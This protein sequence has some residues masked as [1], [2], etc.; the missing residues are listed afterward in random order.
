MA[1]VYE[2]VEPMLERRVAIKV[3]HP[4]LSA[5]PGFAKRFHQEARL[6]ASLRHPNI[7]Q[8]YDFDIQDGQP[9]MV[10]EFLEGGTLKDKFAGLRSRRQLLPLSEVNRLIASLA[11]AL[12]YAHARGAI[13]RDIKPANILFTSQDEPVISDFGIAKLMHE[14]LQI[15]ATGSIIGTPAY[16][17][18]EQARGVSLDGRSDQYSLGIMAYELVAGRVP[19]QAETP[20]GVIM[21]HLS[22]SP[23]PPRN[24]NS[25]L[26]EPLQAAI[27]QTLAKDPA[28]RFESCGAFSIGFAAAL[29]G[30][31][32]VP[33]STEMAASLN[34]TTVLDTTPDGTTPPTPQPAPLTTSPAPTVP[35]LAADQKTPPSLLD[36]LRNPPIRKLMLRTGIA[37]LL[38]VAII[39]GA[40]W[41]NQ[42]TSTQPRT[43]NGFT[44]AIADFDGS[45][46]SLRVDF[47]RRIYDALQ[48][49]LADVGEEITILQLGEVVADTQ[50]AQAALRDRSAS[51]L[52]WGWYDD[53]GVSP[54]VEVAGEPAPG[55]SASSGAPWVDVALAAEPGSG[56]SIAGLDLKLVAPVI[57][58]PKVMPDMEFFV[59]NGPQQIVYITGAVLGLAFQTQGKP[60]VALELYDRAIANVPL[61]E[62]GKS[63]KNGPGLDLVYAR[64]AELQYDQGN[65]PE[66]VADLEHAVALNPEFYAAQYNLGMLYPQVCRPARQLGPALEAARTAATLQADDP[67]AHTLLASLYYQ[68][69]DYT[70]AESALQTA[71]QL[72]GEYVEALQ[73]L[74]D[75]RRALGDA[76]GAKQ[77]YQQALGLLEANLAGQ[78]KQALPL[79]FSIG[80]L[81][82][83]LDQSEAARAS[84]QAAADAQP[85]AALTHFG[86]G[87]QA[88]SSAQ[89]DLAEREYQAFTQAES[90]NGNAW[91]LLGVAQNLN[92]KPAQAIESL[93]RADSLLSCDSA[94]SLILGG[95]YWEQ[96]LYDQA[97]QAFQ[98]VLE[99]EPDNADAL[100]LLGSTYISQDKLVEAQTALEGAVAADGSLSQARDALGFVY[101]ETGQYTQAIE[102][103]RA[104]V[105]VAPQDAAAW[106][107]LGNAYEKNGELQKAIE[108]YQQ[109]LTIEESASVH[110]YLGLIY[111]NLGQLQEAEE[112][113]LQAIEI[114][115]TDWLAYSGLGEL[116][117]GQGKLEE[118]EKMY[119]QALNLK[120][121]AMLYASLA[122]V[123][124][125]LGKTDLAASQ[126]EKALQ[127]G[128]ENAPL[129]LHLAGIYTRDGPLSQA[130][131]Q[132]QAL[133]KANPQDA[134]ALASLGYLAYKQCRLSDLSL[135]YRQAAQAAPAI[136]YYQSLLAYAD[137]IAGNFTQAEQAYQALLVDFPQDALT[138]L[139]NGEFTQRSGDLDSAA[140]YY[141]QVLESPELAPYVRALAHFD[142]GQVYMLQDRLT[143]AENEFSAALVDAPWH[144]DALVALGDLALRQGDTAAA[145][146][147][148]DRAA[149]ALPEYAWQFAGDGAVLSEIGIILRR[150]IA[151]AQ[152]N[153]EASQAAYDQ[154]LSKAQQLVQD[155]PG[156]P[157][158]HVILGL[159][160][161]LRNE[162][163]LANTEYA[164][165]GECN[166]SL[167][168]S[169]SLA[170]EALKKL[171]SR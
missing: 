122:E 142:L 84:F 26:P 59:D 110:L 68:T 10:M 145:T 165:A 36:R 78:P 107:S 34:G 152:S 169:I 17:S 72:D 136:A 69:G 163:E 114:D 12:D 105:E 83:Q 118:A 132:Y 37:L 1:T 162:Q 85:E 42:H 128:L 48:S 22:E 79:M 140:G 146:Q 15:S 92:G 102:Q 101:Y 123:S 160:Y 40:T 7:V 95:I 44:I 73:L 103:L 149:L 117:M 130:E 139:L 170:E 100:Y 127:M 121:D 89:Y 70:Q 53:L 148:Y 86:L 49:E 96:K 137:E 91:L 56:S 88:F 60:Q 29:R 2:A 153:P 134:Q 144:S 98:R 82:L 106:V 116:Y 19:F 57:R 138:L 23:P 157:Q 131:E 129:R 143:P 58:T 99:L 21:K 141:Q 43:A 51:L 159:A 135:K 18:P 50:A 158:A 55:K 164:A 119:D 113:Y 11:L 171:Q 5:Q 9:F 71:L 63:Q 30:G 35:E 66:A 75:V 31:V 77:S 151:L 6:V 61:V 108:A 76:D 112:Q 20:T 3:I 97:I 16:M 93:Q 47:A 67:A 81:Y 52:V 167:Q 74:G 8:L 24:F 111:S 156:W 104:V 65:L 155:Y 4:H 64:R 28:L 87:N 94:P 38:L 54:H 115:N 133:L 126:Y 120:E 14:S 125:R 147:L 46:A 25:N 62:Q 32:P 109:S 166:R 41:L 161:A 154:A 168:A 45:K 150:G 33:D 39:L 90:D 124:A 27:L 13:H 80:N